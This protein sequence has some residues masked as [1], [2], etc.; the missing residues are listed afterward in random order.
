M[1]ENFY[2]MYPPQIREMYSAD[3]NSLK[4][5]QADIY[6]WAEVFAEVTG[7]DIGKILLVNNIVS[8]SSWC[9]SILALRTDGQVIHARNLDFDR[10]KEL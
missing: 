8:M 3:V 2:Y 5:A 9:T 1:V 4:S 10:P 6:N 7:Q